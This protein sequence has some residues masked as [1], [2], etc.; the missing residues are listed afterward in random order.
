MQ[1]ESKFEK[2]NSSEE[3]P[4]NP[5]NCWEFLTKSLTYPCMILSQIL[6]YALLFAQRVSELKKKTDLDAEA[7]I[8]P[9]SYLHSLGLVICLIGYLVFLVKPFLTSLRYIFEEVGERDSFKKNLISLIRSHWFILMGCLLCVPIF[10]SSNVSGDI[11][12]PGN[13]VYFTLY[14]INMMI[15]VYTSYDVYHPSN[16]TFKKLSFIGNLIT[17]IALVTMMNSTTRKFFVFF[18]IVNF[19]LMNKTRKFLKN[20]QDEK[21][22]KKMMF[23][24]IF[25]VFNCML[26]IFIIVDMLYHR[27]ICRH[28][29]GNLF[30]KVLKSLIFGNLTKMV[31]YFM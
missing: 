24:T 30:S 12:K 1:S 18:K 17:S 25:N 3:I 27:Q 11:F 26:S 21:I 28:E 19:I 8:S 6:L 15:E 9:E 7:N 31:V 29:M 16:N 2:E 5:E 13:M 4:K 10:I 22:K 23:N 14:L 20:V